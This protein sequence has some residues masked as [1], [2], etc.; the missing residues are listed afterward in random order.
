MFGAFGGIRT[1]NLLIRILSDALSGAIRECHTVTVG[2]RERRPR[3]DCAGP[4]V[5]PGDR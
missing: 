2:D 3:S 1:P 4:G 5:T